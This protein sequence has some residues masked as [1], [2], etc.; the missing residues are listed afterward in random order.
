MVAQRFVISTHGSSEVGADAV[1]TGEHVSGVR[2]GD[3]SNIAKSIEKLA[4]RFGMVC[5]FLIWKTRP[6]QCHSCRGTDFAMNTIE[7]EDDTIRVRFLDG[8]RTG[9][10]FPRESDGNERYV[11]VPGRKI[12]AAVFHHSA[13][14]FYRGIQAV[15]RIAAFCIAPP[16]YARD[17]DG[18]FKLDA[19]GKLVVIGGGRGWPGIPYTYVIPAY[20]ELEDG[21]IVLYKIWHDDWVTWHTGGIYN[22]HAVGVVIGGWYA[23]RHDLLSMT[24]VGD[25]K[26]AHERPSAE[27]LAGADA[28]ADHLMERHGLQLGPDTLKCHAELGKPAC[29]GAFLEN[30]VRTKRGEEPILDPG[31]GREDPRDLTEVRHIQAALLELGYRPG[32]VDNTMG[33]YTMHAIKAFQRAQKLRAD[34]IFGPL[35]RQSMRLALARAAAPGAL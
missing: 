30:W 26:A 9:P 11:K 20:P 15:E 5:V 12:L 14:G 8:F 3:P 28:L 29:P 16:E 33:P 13:G 27:A 25:G 7:H 10:R 23:S 22:H 2:S 31:L 18:S 21:K 32:E 4:S 35:T 34:G 6:L 24:R 19:K 17:E 1:I